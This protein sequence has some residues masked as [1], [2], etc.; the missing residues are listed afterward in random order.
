MYTSKKKPKKNQGAHAEYDKS[1]EE[2]NKFKLDSQ[3]MSHE[4]FRVG[5]GMSKMIWKRDT[6]MQWDDNNAAN[7]TANDVEDQAKEVR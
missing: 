7:F 6:S 4:G 3:H 1:I 5:I 2:V